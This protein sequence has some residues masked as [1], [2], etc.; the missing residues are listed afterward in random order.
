MSVVTLADIDTGW[1]LAG[2][3]NQGW[4]V[5][6][7]QVEPV[8]FRTFLFSL[9]CLLMLLFMAV[10][11][12]DPDGLL[13]IGVYSV[14]A[15]WSAVSAFRPRLYRQAPVYAALLSSV[16]VS[17]AVMVHFWPTSAGFWNKAVWYEVETAREG[18]G[19]MIVVWVILLSCWV[20][21]R[22]RSGSSAEGLSLQ[23]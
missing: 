17:L 9:L 23:R 12:N 14:P 21:I 2:F 19:M 1:A 18:M 4:P 8:M 3:L 13:W 20:A 7:L 11:Y 16:V 10:Q 6:V 15:I 22:Y 5:L